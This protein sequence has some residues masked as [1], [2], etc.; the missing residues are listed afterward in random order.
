[1]NGGTGTIEG[2]EQTHT[3]EPEPANHTPL[4]RQGE[5]DSPGE[6]ALESQNMQII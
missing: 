2:P 4:D 3:G 5:P 6:P 1:M